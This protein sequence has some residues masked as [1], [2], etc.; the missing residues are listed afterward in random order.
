[1]DRFINVGLW[2]LLAAIWSSSYAII[3]IGVETI[4]P[5]M[6]V[7]GRLSIATLVLGSVMWLQ[8]VRL[9]LTRN[10]LTAYAVTGILGNAI[11][12]F[13]ITYGELYVSSSLAAILMG[14]GPISTVVMAHFWIEAEKLTKRSLI[15]VFVGFVGVVILFGVDA[16]SSLGMDLLGQLALTA[17]ALCYAA[18]TVI[19]KTLPKRK[20][21]EMAAGSMLMGT[22]AIT[23]WALLVVDFGALP[24]PSTV[25]ISAVIFLGLIPTALA[26]LIYFFL[27]NRIEAK[28]MSQI[29]FAVP[30]GGAIVGI[31]FLGE[32]LTYNQVLAL[33]I[34]ILA[35]YLVTSKPALRAA[36]FVNTKQ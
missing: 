32:E 7:L 27:M 20:P 17:A 25:G 19:V 9:K 31:A 34:I 11:P 28:Q 29:N 16:L 22:L 21:I 6:L 4:D 13:L 18:T 33:P 15:G 30:V 26:M 10:A 14:V 12:F 1:M 2:L 24:T 23:I 8:G 35:I 5:T 3:K 36:G